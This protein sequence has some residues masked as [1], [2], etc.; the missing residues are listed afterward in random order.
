MS[1][2][3][4][5]FTVG[6]L[7]NSRESDTVAFLN[8]TSERHKANIMVH[9]FPFDD[10]GTINEFSGMILDLDSVSTCT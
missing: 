7:K 9:F 6:C 1:T 4:E 5:S 3:D 10:P 8:V 2:I